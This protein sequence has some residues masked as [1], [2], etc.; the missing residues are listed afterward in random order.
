M[1]VRRWLFEIL[2]RNVGAGHNVRPRWIGFRAELDL[3]PRLEA[4]ESVEQ[5]Y[6]GGIFLPT[7]KGAGPLEEPVYFSVVPEPFDREGYRHIFAAISGVGCKAMF[8][9]AYDGSK[10]VTGWNRKDVMKCG[11]VVPVPA[12]TVY[13]FDKENGFK[14]CWS[15]MK[16]LVSLY[17]R[18][19]R[20]KRDPVLE[21][22]ELGDRH[23][24]D[25]FDD[26]TITTLYVERLVF[27]GYL[28]FGV[29]RGIPADIDSIVR[30]SDGQYFM[31]EVKEKD[32][33]KRAPIGFGMDDRRIKSLGR[34][35][36]LTGMSY[37]YI[38]REIDNQH[39]RNLTG[40]HSI[41]LNKFIQQ[42]AAQKK[43]EGGTGMRSYGSSNPT[44]VCPLENF[45]KF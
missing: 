44:R 12:L 45:S 22:E 11:L 27:D 18:Y 35:Q 26:Q 30:N 21:W 28:G 24:L 33:S 10:P 40:W 41:G 25:E 42:T 4:R 3:G 38:V 6:S 34:L 14:K 16:A 8:L 36:Q 32:R 2:A 13:R 29:E 31:I 5:A 37:W 23:M 19:N 7:R 9:I 15:G 17:R 1:D 43:I 39:S 20:R